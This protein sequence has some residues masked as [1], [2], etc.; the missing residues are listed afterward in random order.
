MGTFFRGSNRGGEAAQKAM[1]HECRSPVHMR[2]QA[3]DEVKKTEARFLETRFG[4]AV[5]FFHETDMGS[6]RF[7]SAEP[8]LSSKDQTQYHA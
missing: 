1:M 7:S 2:P 6:V 8:S 4:A 5:S 3:Q